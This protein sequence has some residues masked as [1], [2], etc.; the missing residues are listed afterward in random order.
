M[1]AWNEIQTRLMT[2]GFDPGGI[3]GKFGPRTKS[4]VR[5][6]QRAHGLVDDGIV[7]PK[8]LSELFPE[9]MPERD[10]DP[11]FSKPLLGPSRQWP[12]QKDVEAYFGAPGSNQVMFSCPYPMRLA[13]SLKTQVM[14]F[15]C[16]RKVE[17][18]LDNIFS[19]VLTHYGMDR[20]KQLRLD[21]FGGC[22]NVRKMRG[23]S[24]WSMH[25][26]GIAVDID[27][28]HNQLRWGK[29]KAAMAGR[30]YD[31]YWQIVEKYG[32]V[33]LGRTRNYDWMHFQFARL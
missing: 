30:E 15:S 31:A 9:P 16:N 29:D 24:R 8:T 6:F 12:R 1:K 4:A 25:A 23:G 17:N 18:A 10:T 20:I 32:G 11:I 26:Y 33:S 2:L 5:A 3:D 14:R 7:G 13:W 19:E 21:L 27:P 22:L 28:A